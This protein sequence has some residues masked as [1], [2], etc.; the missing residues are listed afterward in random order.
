MEPITEVKKAPRLLIFDSGL[1]GL[2]VMRAI[3]E[4]V[5]EAAIFYVADDAGFPYGT[6]DGQTLVERVSE[7]IGEAIGNIQPDAAVIACHTASTLALPELRARFHIPFVGTVPAIKPAALLSRTRMVSVL[8]TPAT[9]AR[10]Y[11]RALIAEHGQGCRFNL[12]G[13]D[14][15]AAIA[16]RYVAGERI[17]DESILQEIVP[18]FV[19]EEGVKT[20]VI[21]L[22]CTH[23]PLLIERLERLAAWPVTWLDPAPAIARRAAN[24]LAAA[25]FIVGVG[26]HRPEGDIFFTSGKLPTPA[27]LALISHYGLSL[28]ETSLLDDGVAIREA[29]SWPIGEKSARQS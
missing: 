19:E 28:A 1:G 29:P 25:G 4:A 8:A 22:A 5:P 21:V 9:V 10:D 3:R 17:L 11:T 13:S 16:E 2:T 23:Y 12:V 14:R 27:A 24:V 6:L 7:V 26:T 15:L 18:C 20:D